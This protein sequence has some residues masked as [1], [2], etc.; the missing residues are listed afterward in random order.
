MHLS[1]LVVEKGGAGYDARRTCAQASLGTSRV[2]DFMMTCRGAA[3]AELLLLDS[4]IRSGRRASMQAS[5]SD[6]PST[7]SSTCMGTCMTTSAE[8]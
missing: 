2:T 1:R 5:A 7:I 3:S 8:V 6:W 4:R